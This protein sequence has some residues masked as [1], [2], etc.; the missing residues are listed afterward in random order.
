MTEFRKTCQNQIISISE[1]QNKSL[2]R[3]YKLITSELIQTK[4]ALNIDTNNFEKYLWHGTRANNP[5]VIY[6]DDT[7]GFDVRYANN[8]SWGKGNYFG[9][10]AQVSMGYLGFRN[11]QGNSILLF[12]KVFVGESIPGQGGLVKAPPIP[13]TNRLYD[14]TSNAQMV[15]IYDV[16][17]AYPHYI[18]EFR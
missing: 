9:Q 7:Y 1:I 8:G 13:G 2:Y 12:N 3:K 4:K 6:K 18:V 10:T 17:R 16:W 5:E 11:A 15:V 14:S